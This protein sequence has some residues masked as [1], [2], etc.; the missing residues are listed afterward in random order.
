LFP[1]GFQPDASWAPSTHFA[2]AGIVEIF[3]FNAGGI[4]F[5]TDVVDMAQELVVLTTLAA[6]RSFMTSPGGQR[7]LQGLI[8][9]VGKIRGLAATR[10]TGDQARFGD[11]LGIGG[12][13]ASMGFV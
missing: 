7:L 6:V 4:V 12:L 10:V 13:L 8:S 2:T 1:F 9:S 3:F 5:Y 11:Q